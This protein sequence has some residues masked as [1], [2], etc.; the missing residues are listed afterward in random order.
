MKQTFIVLKPDAIKRGLIGRIISRFE[1]KDFKIIDIGIKEVDRAWCWEMY[2]HVPKDVFN[3]LVEFMT[4]APVI[5]ILL[6]GHNAI[7]TV[8][9]MV[10]STDSIKA[11]PGTIRG[12]LGTYPVMHNCIHASDSP[13]T[14]TRESSLFFGVYYEFD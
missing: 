7:D 13:A 11:H 9:D 2:K 12:D 6:E 10:G 14:V 5:G 1:D 3:D 8:R 4:S